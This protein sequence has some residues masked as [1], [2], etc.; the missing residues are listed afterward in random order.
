[1]GLGIVIAASGVPDEE[2]S[3]AYKIEVYERM[4]ETTTFRIQYNIDIADGDFPTLIDARLDPGA[5]LA[6]IARFDDKDNYLVKGPVT[7]QH[8]RF[9]HGGAGSFVEVSGADS[10]IAMDRETK[11][12]VWSSG[13]DSDAVSQIAGTYSFIPDIDLTPAM[14]DE[15]KHSLLQLD[16]DL[17]FVKRLA[18]RNGCLFWISCDET[19][20]ETAHFRRPALDGD[21]AGNIDINMDTNTV[22]SLDLDWDVEVPTSLV[23]GELNLNDGSPIDGN[24]PL[25]PLLPLGTSSL[26]AITGDTRSV[27]IATPVDDAG[28]L[29]ARGEAA[30]IEAGWFIRASCETTVSAAGGLVRPNTIVNLRGFGSRHSGKYYVA[31]VRHV[32]D[33]SAH[34]MSIELI[35]NAW[36]N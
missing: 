19:G 28:D 14:H 24:V 13:A 1:M 31:A 7:G 25:S 3:D 22:D 21:P 29:Q 4:G 20:R 36:G 5:E 6:V 9:N 35:R 32:I 11:S 34:N 26:A 30:L 8:V 10:S 15:D 33:Q 27:H 18:R 17:R 23:A 2:L 16:S 12:V